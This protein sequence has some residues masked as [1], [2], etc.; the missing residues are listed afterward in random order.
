MQSERSAESSALSGSVRGLGVCDALRLELAA[1]QLPQLVEHVQVLGAS[2]EEEYELRLVERLHAQLP[3]GEVPARFVFVGPTG[4]IGTI[5]R[6]GMRHAVEALADLVLAE[7]SHEDAARARL[8]EAAEAAAAWVQTYIDVQAVE[9]F[10][11]D[12][13][14]EASG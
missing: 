5:V 7:P 12:A 14:P 3:E 6:G 11:F 8:I 10:S 4:M 1:V 13:D 2:L 9:E